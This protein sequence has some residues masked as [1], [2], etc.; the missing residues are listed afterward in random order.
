MPHIFEVAPTGRAKCRGCGNAIAKDDVR[1]G[2]RLPNAFGEGE[3]TLWYHPMCAAYKQP[4][5][6][7][8]ALSDAESKVGDRDAYERAAR[9]TL[10][11]RRLA[12]I[13][14]AERSPTGQAKCRHC[15]AAIERGSWRIRLSYFEDGRFSPGG[16][17]HMACHP[18]YLEGHDALDRI[19]YFSANLEEAEREDLRKAY[20]AAPPAGPA[21]S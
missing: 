21:S 5:A 11:H 4:E 8:E 2:Q 16:F 18:A 10:E 12:R 3:M 1:F 13:D 19:L 9:A 15:R 7:V 20:R 14:G 6:V 17:V